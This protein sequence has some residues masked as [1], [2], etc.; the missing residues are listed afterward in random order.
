MLIELYNEN[1]ISLFD[2]LLKDKNTDKNITWCTNDYLK[3]GENYR[4]EHEI[5]REALN[6]MGFSL[7]DLLQPRVTKSKEIQKGRTK[8]R[9]EVF[10]PSWICEYMNNH[11]EQD[12][13]NKNKK[14]YDADLKMVKK[15]FLKS[16]IDVRKLEIT[17]GEAPFVISCYDTVTGKT[18]PLY[19]RIGFLDKKL[20]AICHYID[21]MDEWFNWVC[22]AYESSYGYEYQG[23]NLFKARLNL[24]QTFLDYYDKKWGC[25]FPTKKQLNKLSN[26]IVRN[27][28]QMDGLT[29][30]VP[31]TDIKC[32][33]YNWRS[34][35]NMDLIGEDSMKFDYIV[36]NPPYQET[37]GGT[38]NIDIWPDFVKE[39]NNVGDNVCLIH[40]ARWVIP[41]KQMQATQDMIVNKGLKLFDYYSNASD[42]FNGVDLR[43]G[44]SITY[45]EKGYNKDI[46]YYNNG[47][48]AGIYNKNDLFFSNDFE[49]EIYSKLFI[50]FKESKT[51]QDR[52]I[53][54]VGSLGGSEFGYKKH[55]QMEFLSDNCDVMK[56]PVK[57]WANSGLGSGAR[58][59]WHYIEKEHLKNVPEILFSSRKVMIDKKGHSIDTGSSGNIIGNIPQIVPKES[60]ASGDVFFVFPENDIDYEL[61]LIKSMFLTKTVRFL[62]SIKQK[63]QYVRGFELVPD[64]TLFITLLNGMLF[65]DEW[66]YKTFN[67]SEGL[68]DWIET[69]ISAK[70]DK[71]GDG[72]DE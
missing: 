42:I 22:R 21:D 70:T 67:F 62:M 3:Y 47:I 31:N 36:G 26:I 17:C 7:V 30:T 60:T 24:I 51:I 14:K 5:T 38:K 28:W 34:K 63:D 19:N 23:D 72:M 56:N 9:A 18:I 12:W 20:T 33:V 13:F 50:P 46:K 44:V 11:C 65:T 10:T 6:D 8:A 1:I 29:N 35:K 59:A 25:G 37:K 58:F 53:G 45:F 16:Y 4:A 41:K 2:I 43:G 39:A 61:K 71:E 69:H 64:Y 48:Y 66:F 49:K 54:N 55:G 40:P 57:I 27:F 52:I 15:E 32:K 68:I